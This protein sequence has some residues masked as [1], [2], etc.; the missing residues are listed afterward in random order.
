MV[1]TQLLNHKNTFNYDKLLLKILKISRPSAGQDSELSKEL[2]SDGEIVNLAVQKLNK[3]KMYVQ[4]LFPYK[5]CQMRGRPSTCDK[6]PCFFW[7]IR[8]KDGNN[9]LLKKFI[10]DT[11]RER[12][13]DRCESFPQMPGA[14]LRP[15]ARNVSQVTHLCGRDT[16]S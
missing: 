9:T 14:Q 1:L 6:Q 7:V 13:I 5:H 2:K 3:E 15:G 16:T 11:G 12:Q 10:A 8:E 4:L